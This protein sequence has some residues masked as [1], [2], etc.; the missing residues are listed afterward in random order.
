M[1][2]RRDEALAESEAN[3]RKATLISE[4]LR[5]Q[6][7]KLAR[8]TQEKMK[9]ERDHRAALSLAKNIDSHSSSDA[10]YYKRRVAEQNGQIQGLN[11]EL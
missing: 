10:D 2:S 4:D 5:D 11:G 7:K 6:K 9:L 1:V 3:K 8:V